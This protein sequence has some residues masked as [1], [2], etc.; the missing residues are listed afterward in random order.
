MKRAASETRPYKN[1]LVKTRT[2]EFCKW[3]TAAADLFAQL[4]Q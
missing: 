4:N 3:F 2:G 1:G